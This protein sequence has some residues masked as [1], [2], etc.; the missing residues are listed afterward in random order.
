MPYK[1]DKQR[2]FFHAAEKRGDIKESVV[3]EWDSASKGKELPKTADGSHEQS[4]KMV[5]GSR[6]VIHTGA[7][8]EQSKHARSGGKE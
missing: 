2:K 1:S 6:S 7:P 4:H 3:K 5:K 8:D